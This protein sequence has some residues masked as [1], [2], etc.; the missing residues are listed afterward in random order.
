MRTY[1][2]GWGLTIL[3][4]APALTMAFL[5]ERHGPDGGAPW[6]SIVGLFLGVAWPVFILG[7]LNQRQHTI[8]GSNVPRVEYRHESSG[9]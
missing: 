1:V 6:W 4:L 7:V 5:L 8:H 3:G 9:P 2:L